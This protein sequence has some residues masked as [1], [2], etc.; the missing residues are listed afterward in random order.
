[1]ADVETPP[2][3]AGVTLGPTG[4]YAAVVTAPTDAAPSVQAVGGSPLEIVRGLR[5]LPG[6]RGIDA[7]TVDLSGLML[8]AL[9]RREGDAVTVVRVV[10]RPARDDSLARS[11]SPVV[12]ALI[13]HRYTIRGG[14]DLVGDELAP[15]DDAAVG[16]L[17]ADLAAARSHAGSGGTSRPDAVAIVGAGS[18]ANP[19]HEQYVAD[20]IRAAL[21][22]IR[23]S[24]ASDFGG[25]GLFAREATVVLD[26]ALAGLVEA[27]VEDW[28]AALRTARAR[29]VLRFARCDGGHS[30]GTVLVSSPV[31]GFAAGNALAA[32]GGAHLAATPDCRV[33]YTEDGHTHATVVRSGLPLAR[34]A[35]QSGIGTELVIPSAVRATWGTDRSRDPGG[36]L[37]HVVR[38][39][40]P[41]ELRAVG[42]AVA[43]PTAWMDLVASIDD[44]LELEQL[45]RQT[46]ERVLVMLLSDD[47]LPG[48]E[49]VTESSAMAVPY[50]R[51]GTV[52]LVVRAEGALDLRRLSHQETA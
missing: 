17:V 1:M 36:D 50:S 19:Q 39:E 51:S 41:Q 7:L 5:E 6:G 14:H 18:Q 26:C 8:A 9:Q 44:P 42:A 47:A 37:P 2:V 49:H 3:L 40:G 15:L 22:D 31:V 20:R 29:W 38:T 21:P 12:E 25:H 52:R 34:A 45:R 32:V 11:P 43:R 35:Q 13:E 23:I 27:A 33:I 48:S 30:T 16:A 24:A 10:P 28:Q 4:S 46:E